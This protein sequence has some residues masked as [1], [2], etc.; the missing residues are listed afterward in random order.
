MMSV[1]HRCFQRIVPGHGE[2][3]DTGGWGQSGA[4]IACR[5]ARTSRNACAAVMRFAAHGSHPRH[6]HV[7]VALHDPARADEP[8]EHQHPVAV[9]L[10]RL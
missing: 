1:R 10:G 9:I 8:S 2:I 3:V 5:A 4:R 7:E 6:G